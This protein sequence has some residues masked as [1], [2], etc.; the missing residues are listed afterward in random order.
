MNIKLYPTLIRREL[1][2]HRGFLI[3]TP[4]VI[5]LILVALSC[6][7]TIKLVFL[8][9]ETGVNTN[10]ESGFGQFLEKNEIE[11]PEGESQ[12]DVGD[13]KPQI[14]AIFSQVALMCAMGLSVFYLTQCLY[15]DRKDRSIL[16]WRSLPFSETD[17]VLSKLA[18]GIWVFPAIFTAF[19]LAGLILS[20]VILFI[21]A[22]VL[23]V[24][25]LMSA[26]LFETASYSLLGAIKSLYLMFLVATLTAPVYCWFLFSSAF[27]R[28]SPMLI[29][30]GIPIAIAV[31]EFVVFGG[32]LFAQSIFSFTETQVQNAVALSEFQFSG[33]DWGTML[34]AVLI[35]TGFV[36]AAI[37]LRNNRYEI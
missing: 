34:L 22:K 11:I 13:I 24:D 36:S 16:F 19:A 17:A 21:G 26:L 32:R 9:Y 25:K 1:A 37:W 7:G 2:E 28:K 4:L 23:G 29:A 6:V 31:A 27:A 14:A 10:L 15:S 5:S 3:R 12:F 20:L 30:F 18:T 35:A 33:V 8:A